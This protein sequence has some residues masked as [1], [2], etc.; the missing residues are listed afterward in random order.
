MQGLNQL[1]S[2][3]HI[4][5]G[6]AGLV[7]FFFPPKKSCSIPCRLQVQQITFHVFHS[8]MGSENSIWRTRPV[9]GHPMV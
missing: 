8:L 6:S 7:V 9:L 5:V 3:S 2:V 1:V 4:L